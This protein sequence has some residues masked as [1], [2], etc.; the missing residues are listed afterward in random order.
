MSNT[1]LTPKVIHFV[2][3]APC[4]LE[5]FQLNFIQYIAIKSAII[6]NP[7]YTVILHCNMEPAGDFWSELKPFV[8]INIEVLPKKVFDIDIV[9]IEHRVD[10]FRLNLLIEF[11]GVYL[12]T[13]TITLKSFDNF[14]R[15]RPVMGREGGSG[16]CNAV[17]FSPPGSEFLRRWLA[18]YENFH[19]DQW[20]EF[21]VLAPK[22]LADAAP[23]LIDV[24]PETTFFIPS[25]DPES[26]VDLF[27]R[28][29]DFPDAVI[30][31]LW[32][33]MN[34][35]ILSEINVSNISHRKTTYGVA[36]CD[37]LH[38]KIGRDIFDSKMIKN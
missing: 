28:L 21:S 18:L 13:D 14:L 25:F 26:S 3:F 10:V 6:R 17:I 1:S 32:N 27:D 2:Y 24:E 30:F 33:T 4:S 35:S 23:D 20:N 36:A 11:G 16:L 38:A 22:R 31:H 7:D 9:Q 8:Q 34:K 37:V 12:D 5:R 19:N 15:S 29:V